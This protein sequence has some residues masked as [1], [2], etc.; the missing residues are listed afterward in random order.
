MSRSVT[1]V[2]GAAAGVG[3]ATVRTLH[4]AGGCVVAVD[5]DPA[6]AEAFPESERI[7]NLRGDVAKAETANEAVALAIAEYGRVDALVNNAARFLLKPLLETTADEW[8]DLFAVNMR[9]MVLFSQA[10]LPHFV[11]QRAGVIVNLASISGLCGAAGQ[12]AY[13]ATKGAVVMFTKGLAIEHA[14][15]GVRVVAVAPGAIDTGFVQKATRMSDDDMARIS[16]PVI[17]ANPLQRIANPVEISQTIQFLLSP[18]AGFITGVVLPV[19]GGW[20]AQ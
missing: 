2:T 9:S 3:A 5:I 7:A 17:A 4:E 1:I 15:D 18:S 6:I 8:D 12:V 10:V 11:G 16:T 19:D 13:G 20:T 14:A